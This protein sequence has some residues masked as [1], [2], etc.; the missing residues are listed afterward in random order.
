MSWE[1]LGEYYD[2]IS[3]MSGV[4]QDPI[5]HAEGDVAIHTQQVIHAIKSLL[6][7]KSCQ[8]ESNKFYGLQHFYMM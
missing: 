1:Q 8:K 7:T 4:R 5:H 2:E 3:D 6:N